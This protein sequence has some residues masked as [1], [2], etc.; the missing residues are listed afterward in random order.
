MLDL[1]ELVGVTQ[2]EPA[3]SQFLHFDQLDAK[4]FRIIKR[5]LDHLNQQ[6]ENS[7]IS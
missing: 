3:N 4:S 6:N 2:K 5:L 1:C 7:T